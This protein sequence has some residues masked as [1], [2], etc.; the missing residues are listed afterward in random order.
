LNH[1]IAISISNTQ[2][3]LEIDVEF[4]MELAREV[5]R[6]ENVEHADVSIAL[7][8]DPS[9]HALN[10]RHLE[11]DWPTD[12]ITFPLSEPD[13]PC[14][15][16]EL[17]VSA[18]MAKT[19]AERAGTNPRDELALYVVHG[20]LHLCGYDDLDDGDRILMRRR[21]DE[22]LRAEGLTNTFTKTGQT[23]SAEDVEVEREGESARWAG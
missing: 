1:P 22:I 13:E 20:L 4:L 19:T 15:I 2:G 17:V 23:N 9:I 12:V 7:V 6:G 21:E 10:R 16:G 8:D 14:L 18:E 3:H 5:L 11:H